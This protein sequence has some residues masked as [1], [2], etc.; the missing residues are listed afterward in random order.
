LRGGDSDILRMYELFLTTMVKDDDFEMASAVLQGLSWMTAR[1][2]VYRVSFFAGPPQPK[3]LPTLRTIQQSLQQRPAELKLWSELGRE[4]SR[5]SFVFQLAHEVKVNQDFG[6]GNAMDLN[7]VPGTLR[8]T[9]FPDPHRE[10]DQLVTH[11]R[12]IDIPG[13]KNLLE[14]MANNGQ[15]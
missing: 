12:K 13:Q 3:G 5:S 7:T 15:M 6:S 2:N 10:K 8:W 11:R 9:E 1:H 14:I 4:L